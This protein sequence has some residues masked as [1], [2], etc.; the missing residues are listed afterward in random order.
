[1]PPERLDIKK[2]LESKR[3]LQSRLESTNVN[4]VELKQENGDYDAKLKEYDDFLTTIDIED[5]LDK[6]KE[7]DEFKTRYD[8][9][10]NR[11]RLMDNEYKTMSRKMKLLDEVPCGDSFPKCQFIKDAHVAS[12]QLPSL[13]VDII[14]EIE[15]A[16]TYKAKVVDVNSVEMIE[17]INKYNEIIIKEE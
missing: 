2:L 14:T 9:T 7:Y 12:V 3:S 16:K 17:T 8:D 6:K 13:E 10:V 1:M 11:A 5:L 4:I 15:D